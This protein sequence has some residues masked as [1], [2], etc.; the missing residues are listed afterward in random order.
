[1][2]AARAGV[3]H[4]HVA[5]QLG[6]EVLGLAFITV[7]TA[8]F[9]LGEFPGSQVVPARA[10]GGLGVGRD[11]LHIGA[12][13]VV[14]VLDA[15]GVALAHHQH[16]GGGVGRAVVRQALLP[17]F[18]N[19]ATV[20]VQG[21][22][23]ARQGQ[24]GHIGFQPVDDGAG[25]LARSA[26]ALLDGHV[27][28]GL[29]LPVLGKGLVELHVQLAG[30]V[31]RHIEQRHRLCKRRQ[32]GQRQSACKGCGQWKLDKVAAKVHGGPRF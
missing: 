28:A 23:V 18:G 12:H 8:I 27:L 26:V 11:H 10:A 7:W 3:Q 16:D 31:V 15:L 5:V 17:V 19:P 20:G 14:P 1:M 25:L 30:G 22:G 2:G 24:R 6:D 29:G 21:I 4:G 32:C 13:Q 9:A